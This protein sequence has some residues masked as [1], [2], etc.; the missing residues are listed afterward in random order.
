M[1][2]CLLLSTFLAQLL[3]ADP[4]SDWFAH[5]SVS[6]NIKYYYIE[7]NRQ[8]EST[9]NTS[10]HSNAAGGEL[11]YSTARTHHLQFN[12]AFMTTNGFL[13]PTNVET[14]TLGQDEGRRGN[15]PA[16]GYSTL[17]IANLDYD[18]ETI[19][20]WYGRRIIN[21]PMI[22][23]KKARMLPSVIEGGAIVLKLGTYTDVT[24]IYADKFK[25]RTSKRFTNIIEHALGDDTRAVTGNDKGE[26]Y[27]ASLAYKRGNYDFNLVNMT[28]PDFLNALYADTEVRLD[29]W[30]LSAQ[31]VDQ[32][33]IGN[34]ET[35]LARPN[36]V[37]AGKSIRSRAVGLR[38]RFDYRQSGFD[39]VYRNVFKDARHYD[40][41]ITPWDGNL[42]YAYSSTTNN[43]G[44]S[45]YGNGLTAGGAYVGGTQGMKFGYTQKYD[46]LK[47]QG[48]KTHVAYAVYQNSRYREDQ[49]DLKLILF[50][51]RDNFSVQLKG[52]W[53]DNDT[54]TFK[55]GTVN[56]L[57]WL[58]QFHA[59]VNYKF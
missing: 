27:T 17:G 55:D 13:L 56:Q 29:Q 24:F 28:A 57:D 40:S 43:L 15:D 33:S 7:T 10:H 58:T 20:L 16:A 26:T 37:T 44:Q 46:F 41:I 19:N 14:S 21:T 18:D 45:L 4:F 32:R 59:I 31:F 48:F 52:I 9:L 25:Q 23:P 54:Y 42:L 30:R 11:H 12:T 2:R 50:Y 36:S 51:D 5:G 38:A 6:G 47:L 53:I 22:G 8:F 39:L 3:M 34:A 49:K 35:N 1:R